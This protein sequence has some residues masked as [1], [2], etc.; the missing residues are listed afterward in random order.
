MDK[1][2][3]A[4]ALLEAAL[5]SGEID[6]QDWY[7]E[8]AAVLT[9]A[10]LAQDDPRGQS[11]YSGDEAH[12]RQARELVVDGIDRDGTFLDVGCAN[13][14]LMESIQR[15]ARERGR[16]ME[17]Y[18]LDISPQLADLARRRLAHWAE[19]VYVGNAINWQS[20]MRF[21]FVRTGLE[22]V[23]VRRQRD[24]LERLLHEV[25]A[26]AGRLIIGAFKEESD[27][28]RAEPSQEELVARFGFTIGGRSERPH[29]CDDYLVYRVFWIDAPDN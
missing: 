5:E 16:V 13:G 10:Y 7:R 21:G 15:W 8:V 23:P 4:L 25:V 2:D 1:T 19:R 9:P 27:E 6:E 17:P 18:G 26:P 24:L 22:Y 29:Y 12:W 11:G 20:P 3:N 14:Y 28:T